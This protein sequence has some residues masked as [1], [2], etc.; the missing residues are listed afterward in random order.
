[1]ISSSISIGSLNKNQ[2]ADL[3]L[4]A[5]NYY[6]LQITS[7]HAQKC[8]TYQENVARMQVKYLLNVNSLGI[9][10]S[11]FLFLTLNKLLTKTFLVTEVLFY[12]FT[13][14]LVIFTSYKR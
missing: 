12:Y 7:R 5:C 14:L 6:Q 13:D 8:S 11:S 2:L 10:W 4:T 9:I 1:M 3:L